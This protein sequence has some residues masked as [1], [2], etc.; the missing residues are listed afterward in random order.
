MT[1]FI[2][3]VHRDRFLIN[4]SFLL[5][6]P[7]VQHNFIHSQS[8]CSPT[9]HTIKIVSTKPFVFPGSPTQRHP[10]LQPQRPSSSTACSNLHAFHRNTHH[11]SQH[12]SPNFHHYSQNRSPNFCHCSQKTNRQ[13]PICRTSGDRQ[14]PPPRSH[15]LQSP[16]QPHSLKRPLP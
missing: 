15:L 12:R 13:I 9:V 6:Y 1:L 14:I 2:P 11:L 3:Q 5:I 7:V 4:K 16:P 8:P 10:T